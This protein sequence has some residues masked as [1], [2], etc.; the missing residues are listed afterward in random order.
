MVCVGASRRLGTLQCLLFAG[1]TKCNLTKPPV[2]QRLVS[3]V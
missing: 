3:L 1:V 2:F